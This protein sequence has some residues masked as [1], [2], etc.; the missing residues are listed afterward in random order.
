MIAD[1]D[2]ELP[3]KACYDYE[4][5]VYQVQWTGVTT[6][7]DDTTHTMYVYRESRDVT[8]TVVSGTM[9]V[10]AGPPAI[11]TLKKL[12]ALKAGAYRVSVVGTMDGVLR[13]GSFWLYVQKRSGR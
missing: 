8:T 10:T 11:S 9:G 4:E 5:P 7:T 6:I 1:D 2:L 13:G 3:S 12:S